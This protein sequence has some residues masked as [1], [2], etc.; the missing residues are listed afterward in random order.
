M[1]THLDSAHT[2]FQKAIE[3]LKGEFSRL[4]IGRASAALVEDVTV[5]AYGSQ[6]PLKSVASISIPEPT[7]LA[8]QPWDKGMLNAIEKAIRDSGLGLNPVNDGSAVRIN[9]PPMTEERRKE[10]SKVVHQRAEEGRI[11]VRRSRG[12][13]HSAY[14]Q[15]QK[16]GE[17]TEDDLKMYEK[18]LQEKVDEA[19][20][21]IEDLAKKKESDIMTI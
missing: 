19:N 20:K 12:D 16:D 1:D 7:S 4:Q 8:I 3:H 6:Q 13:A 21:E 14:K 15:L 9:M 2:A 17:L 5:E 11:S 18:K 10:L